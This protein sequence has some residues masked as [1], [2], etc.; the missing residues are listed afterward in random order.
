MSEADKRKGSTKWSEMEAGD[1]K[2]MRWKQMRAIKAKVLI[3]FIIA[4]VLIQGCNAEI[5]CTEVTNSD[6][7]EASGGVCGCTSPY[8]WAATT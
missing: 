8:S 7:L 6:G 1:K 2:G 3:W 5:N 4:I